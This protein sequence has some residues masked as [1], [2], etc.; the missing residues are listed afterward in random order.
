[1]TRSTKTSINLKL[2][3]VLFSP[4]VWLVAL[5]LLATAALAVGMWN[6]RTTARQ[7]LDDEATT[8]SEPYQLPQFTPTVW[9]M[10][11]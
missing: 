11:P 3:K 9:V 4:E 7:K 8:V 5:F 2:T 10:K 6:E 1:M